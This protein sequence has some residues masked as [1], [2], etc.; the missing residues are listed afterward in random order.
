[1]ATV[2]KGLKKVTAAH[3]AARA[4]GRT[5]SRVVAAYLEGIAAHAPRR[6]R[7]RTP[8]SIQQRL[9][10]IAG[11]YANVDLF[12]RLNL[13]QERMNLEAELERLTV[14]DGGELADL[15]A[16]FVEIAAH[17]ADR[18]G[19]THTAWRTVGVPADT[20]R[21]AGITR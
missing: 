20:L 16:A 1:M 11:G 7:R 13:S 12:T 2:R 5:E 17:Y 10:T 8:E 6:G 14:D 18:K 21:H 4:A 15:E 9:D 19:I 3:K